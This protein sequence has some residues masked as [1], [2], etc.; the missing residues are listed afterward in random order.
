MTQSSGRRRMPTRH[1]RRRRHQ[2]HARGSFRLRAIFKPV[3]RTRPAAPAPA[4]AMRRGR[5]RVLADRAVDVRRCRSRSRAAG[6]RDQARPRP[7]RT[8]RGSGRRTST[9]MLIVLAPRQNLRKAEKRGK[10][11]VVHPAPLRDDHLPHPWRDAA[12]AEQAHLAE[13][14]GTMPRARPAAADARRSSRRQAR[15]SPLQSIAS[16]FSLR[17][18]AERSMPMNSAVR[19]ILPPKRLICATR[20]SRSNTSRASRK[21]QAHQLLAAGPGRHRGHQRADFGGQHGGGDLR[22]GIAG[23]EDHQT[24]DVVA[25]L[26]DVARPIVRL[27][28]R[29]RIVADLALRHAHRRRDLIHEECRSV[30]ECPRGVR[31]A[32]ARGSARPRGDG[33]GLRGTRPR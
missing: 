30:R 3:P 1:E 20:Y 31:R 18:S 2:D 27:Q 11:A 23:R 13:R 6:Q 22:F 25:Q 5:V 32:T 16:D 8:S 9:A 29:H 17:C 33:T 26:A 4:P 24:F 21:R 7:H 28:N 10:F 15:P 19:E 14:P 12:E